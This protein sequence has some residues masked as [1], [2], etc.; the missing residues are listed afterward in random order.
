MSE[1]ASGRLLRFGS[2]LTRSDER[3]AHLLQMT[4]IVI[5][6]IKKSSKNFH[7]IRLLYFHYAVF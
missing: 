3:G 1:A 7:T 2:S 6:F 5:N 4:K